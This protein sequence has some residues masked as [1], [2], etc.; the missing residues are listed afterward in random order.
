MKNT[1][2]IIACLLFTGLVQA[3][4]NITDFR[5]PVFK[6]GSY[7]VS[8]YQIDGEKTQ[9][10][11]IKRNRGYYS[12]LQINS[13][14][15][16]PYESTLTLMNESD[17]FGVEFLDLYNQ[18]YG[19][20]SQ[21]GIRLQ[22]RGKG[23]FKPFIIDFSDGKTKTKVF[24]TNS[25]Q[26]NTFYGEL[27]LK[28]NFLSVQGE[29]SGY[30]Y[31]ALEL[32]SNDTV[33]KL[34]QISHK[35]DIP[36]VLSFSYNEG[37]KWQ[38]PLT[39]SDKGNTLIGSLNDQQNA[40]LQV[41]GP[42]YFKGGITIDSGDTTNVI[43]FD[44]KEKTIGIIGLDTESNN[45]LI[46]RAWNKEKSSPDD[47][48]ASIL[49][50][51]ESG[52]VFIGASHSTSGIEATGK[53]HVGDLVL[54]SAALMNHGSVRDM[55]KSAGVDTGNSEV[56]L[57]MINQLLFQKIDELYFRLDSLEQRLKELEK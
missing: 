56:S 40:L 32:K 39:L 19:S 7:T 31:S 42:S 15:K 13:P 8:Q 44:T 43:Q 16:T 23:D 25:N 27:E 14:D 12:I 37:D 45:L 11:D 36:H 57:V 1:F 35:Q 6:S 34:W 54:T 3:Q 29:G 22:K 21:F 10:L 50:S 2:L 17:S 30:S 26:L 9:V 41:N 52:D 49:I 51:G 18:N 33:P 48:L 5:H 20:E 24:E 55:Q 46:S 47:N 38:F 28:G 53:I 4:Q